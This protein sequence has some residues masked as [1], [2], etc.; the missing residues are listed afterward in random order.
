MHT[1]LW[2]RLDQEGHDACRFAPTS[3]TWSIEGA[4]VF[5][6]EGAVANL[7]YRLDCDRYWSSMAASVTGWVG[8]RSIDISIERT[9]Q[10]DWSVD[11]STVDVLSGLED[12][13]LGFTPASNTNAIRRLNL[14]EG[15]E[16]TTTAVW[17]D[18]EDWTVK[19]LLQSYRRDRKDAYYYK[20]PLHDFRA[21]LLVDD[22]AG[23]KEYPG[24]WTAVGHGG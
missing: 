13:D 18:T 7:S 16:T 1:Y 10:G 21:M 11:G 8:A 22:F 4:A 3:G 19:P 12:I 15:D 2:R 20:S 6:H 5:D 9:R 24:L 14:R 23:I 17:L